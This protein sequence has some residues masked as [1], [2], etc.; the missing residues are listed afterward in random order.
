MIWLQGKY[1]YALLAISFNTFFEN[2]ITFQDYED[3]GI[4]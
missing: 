1:F 3:N 4:L 2:K